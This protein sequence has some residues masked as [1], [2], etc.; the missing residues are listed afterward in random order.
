MTE[1][2]KDHF[3]NNDWMDYG[4]KKS[5]VM[6]KA[7]KSKDLS[8]QQGVV[9]AKPK[10]KAVPSHKREFKDPINLSKPLLGKQS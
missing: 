6:L 8:I 1:P 10:L 9:P 5:S 3:K 7:D 4:N 2:S